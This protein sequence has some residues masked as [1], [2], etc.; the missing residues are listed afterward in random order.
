MG[1]SDLPSFVSGDKIIINRSAYD[2]TLP[3]S[4]LKI[5][6]WQKPDRGDMILCHF[7]NSENQDFWLKRIIGLPGDT[8]QIKKNKIYINRQQLKYE[9]IKK[10][11][12][13]PQV[14]NVLDELVAVESG[15]G[16]AHL[17]TF[18][19]TENIL[20]N[21]GPLVIAEDHYFVLGDNRNN[22]LDSRFL[23]VVPRN[24]IYGK[25][26]FRIYRKG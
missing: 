17:V 18:S 16:L 2:I 5:I 11:A 21:Y 4:N 26:L 8:I 1:E 24:H 10:E 20:S 14:E 15:N 7:R 9:L 3:F 19:E 12:F 22:S 25:Y 6:H 13:E 23:G